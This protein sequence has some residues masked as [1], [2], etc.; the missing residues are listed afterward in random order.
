MVNDVKAKKWWSDHG[1]RVHGGLG[2]ILSNTFHVWTKHCLSCYR[3]GYSSLSNPRRVHSARSPHAAISLQSQWF[4]ARHDGGKEIFV[5]LHFAKR[6]SYFQCVLKFTDNQ[7]NSLERHQA[8]HTSRFAIQRTIRRHV[9]PAFLGGL[10]HCDTATLRPRAIRF[11]CRGA[12]P[13]HL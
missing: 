7:K 4:S 1:E 3:V 8:N 2:S 5:F 12:K 6:V 10:W 9:T 13:P 11:F